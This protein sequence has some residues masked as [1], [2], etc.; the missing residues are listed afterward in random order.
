MSRSKSRTQDLVIAS[1]SARRTI[2]EAISMY[3]SESR[4]VELV[5]ITYISGIRTVN[6]VVVYNI[7]RIRSDR[8]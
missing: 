6:H 7:C 1:I 5:K 8:S 2:G 4:I 3:K